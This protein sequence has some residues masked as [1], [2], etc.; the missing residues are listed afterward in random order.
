LTWGPEPL[1][2]LELVR[3][4]PTRRVFI[5][6]NAERAIIEIAAGIEATDGRERT[7][8]ELWLAD[9]HVH[10]EAFLAGLVEQAIVDVAGSGPVRFCHGSPRSDEE[11][12]TPETPD[13]R[14]A[15]LM[16]GVE[17]RVLVSAHTH[18]QFDRSVAGVRSINPGSVG[19]PY[20]DGPASACWALIGADGVDLRATSYDL[21]AACVAYRTTADP[22]REAMVELLLE[23]IKPHV[24]IADA[25]ERVFAG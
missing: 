19:M 14:I 24:L 20:C 6:G 9:L 2:T 7:P 1:E 10:E 22:I 5:R 17:E 18:L 16:A 12:I 25:E 11:C 13:E 21:E 8:R 3:A 15:A 4:L 23:P